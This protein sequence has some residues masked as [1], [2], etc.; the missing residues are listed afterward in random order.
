MGSL[1]FQWQHHSSVHDGRLPRISAACSPTA[2][3]RALLYVAFLLLA[4]CLTSIY[5]RDHDDDDDDDINDWDG[6]FW[7]WGAPS[8][9]LLF[10]FPL[11]HI[12]NVDV[13]C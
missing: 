1:H 5:A 4:L 3:M 6:G 9:L 10:S 12:L 13:L 2:A 7:A 11:V 8:V